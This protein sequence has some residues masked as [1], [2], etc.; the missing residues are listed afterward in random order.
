M[1][2]RKYLN[3]DRVFLANYSDGLSDVPM[4][5]HIAKFLAKPEQIA[6]FVA[7]PSSQSFHVVNAD[8]EG[9]VTRL[10]AMPEQQLSIN[11]GFFAL[12]SEI[13]DYISE[14][15]ELVEQPFA[16]LIDERRLMTYRWKGF[17]QC[18]DTLKDKIN[19][20]RMDARGACPWKVWLDQPESA[21]GPGT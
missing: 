19:F 13:F 15:E 8:D 17:W 11:G 9:I 3:N 1:R 2:I 6:S 21:V 12:R 16:R 10:G 18:M 14:G 7:V 5:D 4:D 20:D